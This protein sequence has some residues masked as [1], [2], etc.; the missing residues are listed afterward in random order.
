MDIVWI[1]QKYWDT[2]LCMTNLK[3]ELWQTS[4][5][6]DPFIVH[7]QKLCTHI[8]DEISWEYCGTPCVWPILKN[9]Q[10]LSP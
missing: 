5:G 7:I 4:V 8:E 9:E 2:S 3:D 1:L 6:V 10:K